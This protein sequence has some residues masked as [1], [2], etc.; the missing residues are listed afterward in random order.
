MD[1]NAEERVLS[2]VIRAMEGVIMA[3][4]KVDLGETGILLRLVKP[5]AEE[6]GSD[7][8]AFEQAIREVREDGVV[9]PEES[10]RLRQ[11]IAAMADRAGGYKVVKCPV[12]ERPL[13]TRTTDVGKVIC[14]WCSREIEM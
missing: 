1:M 8:R 12:C 13:S 9:T 4:G 11:L 7:F 5:L 2:N 14:P 6:Y 3:D 10:E